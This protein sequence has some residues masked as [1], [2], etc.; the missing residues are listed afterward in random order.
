MLDPAADPAAVPDQARQAEDAGFDFL[1]AGEHVFFHGPVSNAFITL[2][3]AA[4]VTTRVRLLSALTI[5]PL[6]PA[7]LAAK[8]IATMDGLSS[9]RFDLGV[10]V[11]GEYPAEF[12]A[13][14]VPVERRGAKTNESLDVLARLLRGEAVTAS[15]EFG[16]F[17]D[18]ALQPAPVQASVPT[19]IGGRA[20]AAIRRAGRYADWWL[21]YLVTPGMLADSLAAVRAAAVEHGRAADAVMG[22]AFLWGAVGTDGNAA[23]T[24]AVAT[25]SRIYDQDFT[26]L[27]EKYLLTGTP[28]DV[29][30]GLAGYRAA[31]AEAVVFAPACPAVDRAVMV[32]RFAADVLPHARSL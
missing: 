32:E 29:L 12:E 20:P 17:A 8:M 26:R 28:D 27:A 10:G 14:G 9:G 24:Q 18:L 6:Y 16:R 1:A 21:P 4:A 25:V 30:T 5:L 19:W 3:A 15:G 23:R 22:A 7:A 11:G 31:G 2:A 13:C